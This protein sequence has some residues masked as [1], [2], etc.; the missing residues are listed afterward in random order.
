MA[1]MYVLSQKGEKLLVHNHFIHRK[2]KTINKKIIWKC[3]IRNLIAV[4]VLT[5]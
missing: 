1:L 5:L 4:V 3:N 2:E